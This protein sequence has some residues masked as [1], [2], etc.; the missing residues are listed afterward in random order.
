M[1][2][3]RGQTFK[4]QRSRSSFRGY[5]FKVHGVWLHPISAPAP[6]ASSPLHLFAHAPQ[7]SP[8]PLTRV[9]LTTRS[10]AR[11]PDSQGTASQ[12]RLGEREMGRDGDARRRRGDGAQRHS[13]EK[14]QRAQGRLK[15]EVAAGSGQEAADNENK[16]DRRHVE[17]CKTGQL[18]GQ[19]T[20]SSLSKR[21]VLG[22][23]RR[24]QYARAGKNRCPWSRRVIS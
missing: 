19:R 20:R 3:V 1:S 7:S 11:Q 2:E 13:G 16:T 15:G 9:L 10:T 12:A 17:Q 23:S 18:R 4:V 6:R 8:S 21:D 14:A 22:R 24:G 5:R